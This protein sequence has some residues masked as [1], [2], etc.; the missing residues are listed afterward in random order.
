MK[1]FFRQPFEDVIQCLEQLVSVSR[2]GAMMIGLV[3]IGG[4]TWF[5]YVPIHELLH[6]YGCMWT[7]GTV[8]ELEIQAHYFGGVLSKFFPWVTTGGDYAGRLTGFDTHGSDLI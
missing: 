2:P 4:I 7:G 5:V 3:F 8:T 1:R 6:A